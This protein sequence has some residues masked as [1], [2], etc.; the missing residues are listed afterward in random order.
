MADES[1]IVMPSAWQVVCHLFVQFNVA[2]HEDFAGRWLAQAVAQELF[3]A[4]AYEALAAISKLCGA[5]TYHETREILEGL[6]EPGRVTEWEPELL[7]EASGHHAAAGSLLMRDGTVLRADLRR[8]SSTGPWPV[9]LVR[10][11]YGKQDPEILALLDQQAAVD[12]GYLVVIQDTRGRHR[13]DGCWQPLIHEQQDGYDT[14]RWAAGLRGCDGRVAM[15]GPSYL[16]HTQWAALLS[17]PPELVAAVPGFTWSDPYDGLVA[18]GGA[19]ELGLVTQWSLTLGADVLHRRHRNRPDELRR[20]LE[21]LAETY[22]NLWTRTGS[23]LPSDDLPTLHALGLPVPGLP[24][25]A[26]LPQVAAERA[27]ATVPTLTVAG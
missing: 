26:P 3:V 25:A 1:L 17:G 22:D 6:V 4:R 23:E 18:R 8:P 11:P 19:R 14:V 2:A 5:D 15:Y 16:G 10:S 7:E 12:R 13:S 20:A 21:R 24:G 27:G 9:L